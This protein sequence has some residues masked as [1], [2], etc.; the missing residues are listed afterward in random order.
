MYSVYDIANYLIDENVSCKQ[1]N[2]ILEA[3]WSDRQ[4]LLDSNYDCDKRKF[5]QSVSSQIDKRSVDLD[6]TDGINRIFKDMGSDFSL[7]ATGDEGH[8]RMVSYF[9]VMKLKLT[10]STDTNDLRMKF[11]TLLRM[12][13]Y[14]RRSKSFN[15]AIKSGLDDLGLAVYLKGNI[16]CDIDTVKLDDMII[17]RLC[18]RNAQ[19][20]TEVSNKIDDK[21]DYISAKSRI[22]KILDEDLEI[23]TECE[24]PRN[25]EFEFK[26]AYLSQVSCVVFNMRRSAAIFTDENHQKV[27]KLLRCYVSEIIEILKNSD[28]V[29][30]VGI[31]GDCVYAFYTTP[32]GKDLLGMMDKVFDV[33]TYIMMLNEL[34]KDKGY[35]LISVG[36]GVSTGKELIVRAGREG[37]VCNSKIWIGKAFNEA[38]KLSS[39][40]ELNGLR[41]IICSGAAYDFFINHFEQRNEKAAR[42]FKVHTSDE[43][44]RYYDANI[45]KK[46]FKSWVIEQWGE[47]AVNDTKAAIKKKQAANR[48]LR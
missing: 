15:D 34:L 43:H 12:F 7:T 5:F 11:R 9:S 40:G 8:N 36:I 48:N 3:L 14:E 2:A 39:L 24:I 18:N 25:Y 17:F 19:R 21:Y 35:P 46:S 42:W 16:L 13:G 22:E 6:E 37:S 29:R 4:N 26:D 31:I 33:N 45:K 10:Y 38:W 44:G 41:S 32:T 27:V 47:D 1:S 23:I 20:P 28:K 30:E